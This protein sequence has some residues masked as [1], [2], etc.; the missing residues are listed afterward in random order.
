MQLISAIFQRL[1]ASNWEAVVC[2]ESALLAYAKISS[3]ASFAGK[4]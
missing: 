1:Y 3:T 2:L 4:K